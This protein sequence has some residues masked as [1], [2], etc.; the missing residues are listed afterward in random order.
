[1]LLD[2]QNK[3]CANCGY[4]WTD[5]Y[6]ES[7]KNLPKYNNHGEQLKALIWQRNQQDNLPEVDHIVPIGMGGSGFLH[8]NLQVLCKACHKEKTK[9][10][11]ADIRKLKKSKS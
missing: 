11:H 3:K 9:K 6:D 8:S 10:D 4:D 7:L 1:M 2:K 5:V